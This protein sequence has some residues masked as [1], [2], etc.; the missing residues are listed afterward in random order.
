MMLQQAVDGR[1]RNTNTKYG[2]S[3]IESGGHFVITWNCTSN[4]NR[5]YTRNRWYYNNHFFLKKYLQ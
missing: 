5:I 1:V 4:G 2:M 3:E